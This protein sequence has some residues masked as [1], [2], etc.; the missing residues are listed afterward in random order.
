MN[1]DPQPIAYGALLPGTPVQANDGV[2]FGTVESVLQVEEVD[3]FDGIV[4]NTAHGVRFVDA[5]QVGQIFT[6][7]VRTTISAHEAA[8]L[9][10]PDQSPVYSVDPHDDAGTSIGDRIGR[11]F[12]RGK[13]KRE[14]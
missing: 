9:P 1:D 2:Q 12:G 5:D 3:V 11:M 8:D 10:V 6:T 4:V 13:W 7:F 14:K